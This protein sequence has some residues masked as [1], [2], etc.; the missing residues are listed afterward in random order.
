MSLITG[1]QKYSI[2]D[3]DGIRTT[4]FFKGCH[5]NC[6]WCHNPE[7]KSFKPQLMCDKE[8][9]ISCGSC[10]QACNKEVC[11]GCG[12]CVDACILNLREIAGEEICVDDLIKEV[13]KDEMFYEESGGGV[14]LS[15]GEAMAADIDYLEAVVKGL[16][17]RGINIAIDTCGY[18]PRN[19]Y[20]R[21]MK[22]IDTFLYDIK[23]M[24]DELHK[25]YI[26]TSNRL[27]KENLEFLSANNANIYIRIPI[28]GT[29]ND[30]TESMQSI[31]LYLK[32]KRISVSKLNLLPYHNT[33]SGKYEKLGEEYK[34]NA[35]TTPESE[36]M[37]EFANLF[38]EA[39]FNNVCIGG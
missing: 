17:R 12:N 36:S 32:E 24:D 39:G 27:I 20:E 16:Y 7:T 31:I 28:I 6:A 3:G 5:L 11:S 29:V 1:V 14:T 18:A 33:G 4:V 26:G 23:I 2:H 10:K 38:K 9:C 25:Q 19:N 21:I 34:G 22:Y 15:G 37:V 35:F 30:T 13:M 8:K